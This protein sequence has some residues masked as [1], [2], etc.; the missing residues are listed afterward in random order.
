MIVRTTRAKVGHRQAPMQEKARLEEA[1]LFVC[2]VT[3][4]RRRPRLKAYRGNGCPT[5]A[6]FVAMVRARLK[7][8]RLLVAALVAVHV[9]VAGHGFLLDVATGAK[10]ALIAVVFASLVQTLRRHALLRSPRSILAL[11][12]HDREKAAI[13]MRRGDW[14]DART[15]HLVRHPVAG[16]ARRGGGR[17]PGSRTTC[18]S[19]AI[20]W[21]LKISGDR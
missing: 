11:E 1:G 2:C 14:R 13:R 18:C 9:A 21:T 5:C 17:H 20:T 7:P 4:S 3:R 15:L 16:R 19:C 8:S 6:L 12:I 10:T